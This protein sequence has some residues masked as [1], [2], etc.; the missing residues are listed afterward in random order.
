M[1]VAVRLHLRTLVGQTAIYGLGG[2]VAQAVGIL[3]VPVF[4]RVLTP[5]EYGALEIYVVGIAVAVVLADAGLSSAAQRSFYD[6][7]DDEPAPRRT[8]LV[9]AFV[10]S[11]ALSAV[12]A[13]A[14]YVAR[15][16]TS[17]SG[18]STG[19]PDAGG[20]WPWRR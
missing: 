12:V 2:G 19:R 4:A 5:A 9:T 11:T 6:Y 18:C 10:T 15:D 14:I 8:V 20:W 13:A 16:P 1:L 7:R 3:T 17:R